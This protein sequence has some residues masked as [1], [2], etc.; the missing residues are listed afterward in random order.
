MEIEY[1]NEDYKNK[2]IYK[3]GNVIEDD[4]LKANLMF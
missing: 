3:V 4:L 2:N 1:R